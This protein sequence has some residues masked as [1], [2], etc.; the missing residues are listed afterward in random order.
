MCIKSWPTRR[1]VRFQKPYLAFPVSW[2]A[3]ENLNNT[4]G[5][6]QMYIYSHGEGNGNPLHYSC[7][8]NPTDRGIWWATVH[9]VRGVG[10]D[11]ALKQQQM[12]IQKGDTSSRK[13]S[14]LVLSFKELYNVVCTSFPEPSPILLLLMFVGDRQG[15]L[16]CCDSWGRKESDT[17]ERLN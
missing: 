6:N 9:G 12:F 4:F 7:L 3:F 15:G 11:S 14:K 16:A 8:G 13:K 1:G 10:H 5:L 2:I 17:T